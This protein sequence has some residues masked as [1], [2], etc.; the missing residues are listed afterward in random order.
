[1]THTQKASA[2]L[3]KLYD[4]LEVLNDESDFVCYCGDPDCPKDR[5]RQLL[6]ETDKLLLD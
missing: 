2:L 4:I 6:E 1:M 5:L 3:A